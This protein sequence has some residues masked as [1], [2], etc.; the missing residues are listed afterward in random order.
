MQGKTSVMFGAIS[1]VV[2]IVILALLVMM[3]Q[4]SSLADTDQLREAISQAARKHRQTLGLLAG[5][6]VT[7]NGVLPPTFEKGEPDEIAVLGARE[8]NSAVPTRLDTI[9]KEIDTAIGQCSE[10]SA[11]V[12]A[13]ANLLLGQVLATKAKY[14]QQSAGN[15]GVQ[16]RK[17]MIAI[18]SGILS[19]QK[20]LNNVQQITPLI[21]TQENS[22]TKMKSDA[23]AEVTRLKSDIAAKEAAIAELE[24]KWAAQIASATAHSNK[25]S[26]LKTLSSAAEREERRSYLEKS[27][28]ESD[29]ANKAGLEA[30]DSQALIDTAKSAVKSMTIELAG[31]EET[32]TSAAGVL[33]GFSDNRDVAKAALDAETQAMNTTR[34]EIAEKVAALIAECEKMDAAQASSASQYVAAL[35]AIKQHR[36]HS[37]DSTES[38]GAEAGILAD[39]AGASLTVVSSRQAVGAIAERLKAVWEAAAIEGDVPKAAEMAAFV[40]KVEADKTAAA[41]GFAAAASLLEEATSKADEFKW[42][43]RCRELQARR[44]RHRLTGDA[45]DQAR[46]TLL[47]EQLAEMKGFPYVDSAL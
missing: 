46:A 20:R 14:C 18:D 31:A 26:E 6:T 45:E 2:V 41:E 4:S 42:S 39:Q 38:M 23:D 22:A 5:P 33:K 43:Y 13:A 8:L 36:Q 37:S 17:A 32:S 25:A 11:D 44:A 21:E 9:K 34:N 7:V 1:I 10:A 35:E 24:T 3:P 47:E 40:E 12:K 16:A 29:L 19:I 15:A 28:T 30:E 27:F